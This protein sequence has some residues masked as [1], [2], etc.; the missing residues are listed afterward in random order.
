M[1]DD[2]R[3]L[4]LKEVGTFLGV[5]RSWLID[6]IKA[7]DLIAVRVGGVWRIS[8]FELQRFLLRNRSDRRI[9]EVEQ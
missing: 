6:H 4:S 3:L 2:N 8:R 1:A 5:G 9:R 7:G